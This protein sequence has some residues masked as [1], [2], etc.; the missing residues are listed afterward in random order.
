MVG[1]SPRAGGGGAKKSV[2]WASPPV[3][4]QRPRGPTSPRPAPSWDP[5]RYLG[6]IETKNMMERVSA[7]LNTDENVVTPKE[8]D[9]AVTAVLYSGPPDPVTTADS[10]LFDV[11]LPPHRPYDSRADAVHPYPRVGVPQRFPGITFRPQP[12]AFRTT[13]RSLGSGRIG[14]GVTQQQV[15]GYT[16]TS[17]PIVVPQLDLSATLNATSQRSPRARGGSSHRAGSA[18]SAKADQGRQATPTSAR[19]PR[20]SRQPPV[21]R[22]AK[23]KRR[24][25]HLTPCVAAVYDALPALVSP[26]FAR[27]SQRKPSGPE[28]FGPLVSGRKSAVARQQR[29]SRP[30]RPASNSSSSRIR[31]GSDAQVGSD[32]SGRPAA[33]VR[34]PTPPTSAR[35][36]GPG[37]QQQA[38]RRRRSS[39]GSSRGSVGRGATATTR[40]PFEARRTFRYSRPWGGVPTYGATRVPVAAAVAEAA[41][42]H[43]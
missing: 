37:Q 4:R 38:G 13:I 24:P 32:G 10:R 14:S 1:V 39:S 12:L 16:S 5:Q 40:P 23:A 8:V 34:R 36:G 22:K 33:A 7:Q 3:V 26:S 28:T 20:S 41:A 43:C 27:L 18:G 25:S 21:A 35:P 29:G 42:A 6:S 15:S 17:I 19:S 31:E 11:P 30:P 2:T 9:G